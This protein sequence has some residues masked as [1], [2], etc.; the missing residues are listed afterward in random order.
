MNIFGLQVRR[1]KLNLIGFVLLLAF[2]NSSFGQSMPDYNMSLSNGVKISDNVIE[3]DV[4]IKAISTNFNLTSYQC[5]F[6]F[7]CDI[8]NGGELSFTYLEGSSH[9]NNLPTFGI[10]INNCDSEPKLTFA[11]MAGSDQIHKDDILVG[12]FRLTNTVAFANVDPNIRW[13]FEGFVSTILTSDN[14]QNITTANFHTSNLTLS[15]NSHKP[16]VPTE[17]QLLQNYPNPFNPHTNI[18]FS[19]KNESE[20]KL[21]VYNLLGEMIKELVNN[22]IAAGNH[23]YTFNSDGLPSGTYLYQLEANNQIIGVKKMTL[24]K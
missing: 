20:V 9:L 2:L 21:V 19:L 3:F 11:S 16:E 12:R 14:F 24:I 17:Y 4:I 15:T 22:K 7:N 5:S 10:G 1:F 23:E 8:A 18:G 13:N 6:I